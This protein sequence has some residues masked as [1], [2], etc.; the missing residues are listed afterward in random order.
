[1]GG[2]SHRDGTSSLAIPN[3]TGRDHQRSTPTLSGV[4]TAQAKDSPPQGETREESVRRG[5]VGNLVLLKALGK[6][7]ASLKRDFSQVSG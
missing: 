4:S 5:K 6:R 7:G 2:S 3:G 1:M